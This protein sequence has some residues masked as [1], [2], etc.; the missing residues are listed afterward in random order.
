MKNNKKQN[1]ELP[2]LTENTTEVAVLE[3]QPEN[4]IEEAVIIPDQP[5]EKN[6]PFIDSNSQDI[7][8]QELKQQCIIPVFAKDNELTVS[9]QEFIEAILDAA[10]D[11]YKGEQINIPAIKVSHLVKGRIPEAINKKASELL[12]KDETMYYSRMAFN[13]QIPTIQEDVV[14]DYLNLSICGCKS[15][16]KEN[17]GG[18][19]SAQTFSLSVGFLNRVCTNQCI[20]TSGFLE[21]MKATNASGIYQQALELF[22]HYNAKKHIN[23]LKSFGDVYLSEHQF[24]QIL[25]RMRLYNYLDLEDQRA[26]PKLLITDS[27]INSVARHYLCDENFAGERNRGITMWKFYNLIT[28]AN[29]KSYIDSFLSRGVNATQICEG[30]TKALTDEDKEFSWFLE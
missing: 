9:H 18:K 11:Y 3:Q 23:L 2:E 12:E 8:L 20:S 7:T 27:Q 6:L 24:C 4:N 17:L 16:E 15:Y 28:G 26:L 5:E 13:I 29:K 10:H 19:L 22:D 30:I 21:V 25:G 1:T 14:G